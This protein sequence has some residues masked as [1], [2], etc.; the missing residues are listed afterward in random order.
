MMEC[1]CLKLLRDRVIDSLH[2]D[3]IG[4]ALNM[5]LVTLS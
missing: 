4:V 3:R 1:H 5:Q 2:S